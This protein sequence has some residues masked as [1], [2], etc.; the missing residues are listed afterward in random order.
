MLNCD[1]NRDLGLT[2]DTVSG[3]VGQ[4]EKMRFEFVERVSGLVA[5]KSVKGFLCA[6]HRAIELREK[7]G[8]W[9]KFRLHLERDGKVSWVRVN[10]I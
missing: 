10:A 8:S 1:E 3:K 4:S 9:E 2:V 5:L 7:V 6:G